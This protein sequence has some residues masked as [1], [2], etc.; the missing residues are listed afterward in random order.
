MAPRWLLPLVGAALVVA[1]A[2]I[3]PQA[4]LYTRRAVTESS[5]YE[6][7]TADDIQQGLASTIVAALTE[8]RAAA[9]SVVQQVAV[10]RDGYL[11][12]ET[13]ATFDV[14][15]L[16]G[17]YNSFGG[18]AD[19]LLQGVG[20]MTASQN[21]TGEDFGNK[22]SFEVTNGTVVSP[23]CPALLYGYT[24]ASAA[25]TSYCVASDTRKVDYA[26]GV[27]YSG[28]DYGLTEQERALMSGA[29]AS[30]LSPVF[31]LVGRQSLSLEVAVADPS[32][33]VVG[34]AFAQTNLELLS[35][36]VASQYALVTGDE[37][38]VGF[39]VDQD[40]LMIAA[41][42]EDQTVY[43][44]PNG[45]GGTKQVRYAA[46][47]ATDPLIGLAARTLAKRFGYNWSLARALRTESA[48][49]ALV[50]DI[51]PCP[52]AA[53]VSPTWFTVAAFRRAT[54]IARVTKSGDKGLFAGMLV[55]S[56]AL[57]GLFAWW[58]GVRGANEARIH[59]QNVH[60]ELT[61]AA[62]HT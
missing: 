60:V 45:Y 40:G 62:H 28:P 31:D 9:A 39:V 13:A 33:A 30:A 19:S 49:G 7:N 17:V 22:I 50:V 52:S 10:L 53:T 2:V 34:I 56:I 46:E 57:V 51:R 48:D 1:L 29:Y 8:L 5:A 43:E 12:T 38:R 59:A 18:A 54:Y 55:L 41:S 16:V 20:V 21:A 32:G 4:L 58:M 3:L 47:N 14:S 37:D 15:P 61:P 24:D 26:G 25:Y 23:A 27:K 42:V 36:R 11:D 6:E 35:A 44:V